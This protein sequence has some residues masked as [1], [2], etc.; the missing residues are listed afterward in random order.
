MGTEKR[1]KC[2]IR[3]EIKR[4][5]PED[6]YI[7]NASFTEQAVYITDLPKDIHIYTK[8]YVIFMHIY[9]D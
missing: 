1:K 3:E 8:C 6:N 2:I 7:Q 9:P 4:K 5:L